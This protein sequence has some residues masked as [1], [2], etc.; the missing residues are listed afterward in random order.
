VAQIIK[1]LELFIV[2]NLATL[3]VMSKRT[4]EIPSGRTGSKR[5]V[6]NVA[7][8][9]VQARRRL[10][11]ASLGRRSE[12]ATSPEATC[13]TSPLS[14]WTRGSSSP[15]TT[16][17]SPTATTTWQVS[18]TCSPSRARGP[19]PPSLTRLLLHLPHPRRSGKR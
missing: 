1:K 14:C 13:S 3:I 8:S 5:L 16:R 18:L 17:T 7:V 10:C 15:S 12:A 19:S 6:V 4:P 2:G 9:R 11:T